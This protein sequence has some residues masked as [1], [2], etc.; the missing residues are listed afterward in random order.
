[1]KMFGHRL[2]W[3]KRLSPSHVRNRTATKSMTTEIILKLPIAKCFVS[4]LNTRQ[5]LPKEVTELAVSLKNTGQT[6]PCIVRPFKGKPGCYE[7][8]AGAR[9]RVACEVAKLTTFDAIIREMDDTTFGEFIIVENLQREDVGPKAEATLLE[10]LIANGVR[11]A[12]AISARLGK[13]KYWVERRLQLLKVIPELRKQWEKGHI[14]HFDVEM[15]ELLGSLPVDTQKSLD[16]ENNWKMNRCQTRK[17]LRAY[18]EDGVLCNLADSPFDLT[19]K[20]FFVPGCGPGCTADS[21]KNG[22]LYDFVGTKDKA[23]CGRCLNSGCFNR[24]L[25][26]WRKTEI[27]RLAAGE[28]L[29]LVCSTYGTHRLS[30]G[31]GEVTVS[32]GYYNL[33]TKPSPGAQ[34]VICLDTGKPVIRYVP[35]RERGCGNSGTNKKPLTDKARMAARHDLLHAKRWHLVHAELIKALDDSRLRWQLQHAADLGLDMKTT[36]L[37]GDL[38]HRLVPVKLAKA[39]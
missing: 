34:K 17:D 11:T 1:M 14:G 22:T 13:P 3:K 31:S 4:V 39:A 8:A 25:A 37:L 9:R 18:L 23:G 32:G 35:K 36:I 15:M 27:E 5:P 30:V 7:I 16:G 38:L 19:D 26:L 29:P 33:Q 20:R 10:N 24:R 12:E 28:D 2:G 6:T 21:S